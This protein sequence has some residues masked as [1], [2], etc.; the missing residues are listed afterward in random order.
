MYERLCIKGPLRIIMIRTPDKGTITISGDR[1]GGI[2]VNL[3]SAV[4]KGVN[5]L[6]VV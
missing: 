2:G 4:T 3:L 6:L 1:M 5:L